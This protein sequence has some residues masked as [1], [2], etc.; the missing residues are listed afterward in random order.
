MDTNTI[1]NRVVRVFRFDV[2]VYREI[3]A[4]EGATMQGWVVAVVASLVAAIGLSRLGPMA[5]VLSAMFT[6]IGFG[7]YAALAA[8][9]SKTFFGGKTDFDEMARTLGFA[10]AWNAV[11][12]LNLIPCAGGLVAFVGGIAAMIAGVIAL[13]ESAEFSTGKAL[14][15]VLVAGIGMILINTVVLGAVATALG[16]TMAVAGGGQ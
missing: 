14:I 7:V 1:I 11:G 16:V 15:T 4:D 13:R 10:Y 9:V 12:I 2:P 3:A 6:V 5:V 8:F